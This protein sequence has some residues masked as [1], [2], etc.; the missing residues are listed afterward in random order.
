MLVYLLRHGIAEDGSDAA[1]D[2]SRRLTDE[3]VR[4]TRQCAK[5]LAK[6]IQ[7]PEALFTSPKV[8]AVQTAEIVGDVLGVKPQV[9]DAL[10]W[11]EVADIDSALKG[12]SVGSV[13]L[14]GHE[15]TLSGLIA[16]WC[17]GSHAGG[18]VV[19]K[20]AGCACVSRYTDSHARCLW[21]LPPGVLRGLGRE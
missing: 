21:V 16:W 15:P 7:P 6:V 11:P 3:G 5:G 1:P 20:K 2:A 4:K 12:V 17:F 13:M 8:R 10:S 19:M 18:V 9:L 14:V